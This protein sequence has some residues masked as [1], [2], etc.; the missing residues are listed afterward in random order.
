MR[1]TYTATGEKLG[2]AYSASNAI[3]YNG[4]MVRDGNNNLLYVLTAEGRYVMNGTTG[5]MEYNIVD[6]LGNVRVVLNDSG[7][8]IQSNDYYPF[9]M[10]M[11]Q[12]GSSTNK[13]LYNGKEVQ[14][15]TGWLDYGW[16][17]YD[18][19]LGRWFNIDP[20]AEDYLSLSSYTYVANNPLLFVDP[21]GQALD[22]YESPTGNIIYDETIHSQKDLDKKGIKGT[23]LGQTYTEGDNYYSLFGEIAN[24]NTWQGKLLEKIDEMFINDFKYKRAMREFDLSSFDEPFEKST[25]FDI[26]FKFKR[27]F[28]GLTGVNIYSFNFQGSKAYYFIYEDPKAMRGKFDFGDNKLV[29]NRGYGSIRLEDGYDMY[30]K[31]N[32]SSK[33]KI[34]IFVFPTLANKNT[35]HKK[36]LSEYEKYR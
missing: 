30:V 9:G 10:L 17:M 26:G 15:Q 31:A 8:V 5:T 20:K 19:S 28:W 22:W 21:D 33:Q 13:Y 11:A 2:V 7:D 36:W 25:N 27:D 35:F 18:N 34:I 12:G 1:Y 24:L 6:H 4:G 16:R 3:T 23:Y 14:E 29:T 32:N